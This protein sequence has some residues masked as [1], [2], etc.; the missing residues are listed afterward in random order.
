MILCGD[1]A[2]RKFSKMAAGPPTLEP[3][4]KCMRSLVAEIWPFAYHGAY[5]TPILGEREVVGVSD[6]T[7]HVPF[8][9]TMVSYKLSIV[10][11]A[12]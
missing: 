8:E 6:G 9:R 2:I 10:T 1:T 12:L 4:M 7:V 11:V 5:G 3:N